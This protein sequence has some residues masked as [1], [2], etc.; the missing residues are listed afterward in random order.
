MLSTSP[1]GAR[2]QTP[3]L[4]VGCGQHFSLSRTWGT[5]S[6]CTLWSRPS[7]PH[8]V[9]RSS[10]FLCRKMVEQ[11]VEVFRRLD[12]EVPEQV[13]EVPKVSL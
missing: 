10:M 11:L 12:I 5:G 3:E 1:H 9:C 8:L 6:S 13:I 2:R 4:M 7:S